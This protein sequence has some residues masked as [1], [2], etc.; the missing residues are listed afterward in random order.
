VEEK[1]R[2]YALI[3]NVFLILI[4]LTLVELAVAILVES[5]VLLMLIALLKAV[6][7]VYYFMH[8]YR[9]WRKGAH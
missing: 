2:A 4:V 3:R 5:T 8:I 6:L 9:L 1:K 7:V